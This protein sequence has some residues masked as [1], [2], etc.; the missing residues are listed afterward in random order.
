MMK[1]SEVVGKYIIVKD[2]QFNDFYKE[3]GDIALCDSFE[4]ANIVCGMYE[5]PDVLI[6]KIEYNHVEED[7]GSVW[8]DNDLIV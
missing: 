1:N 7:D 6:L 8:F 3:N 2:L 5:F 4:E